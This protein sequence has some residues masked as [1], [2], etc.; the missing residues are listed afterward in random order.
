MGRREIPWPDK[1]VIIQAK[2]NFRN[3]AMTADTK[4]K[5]LR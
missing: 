3:I 4:M 5:N 1:A 2:A